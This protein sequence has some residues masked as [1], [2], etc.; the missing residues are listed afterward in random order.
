MILFYWPKSN[1]HMSELF[2]ARLEAYGIYEFISAKYTTPRCRCLTDGQNG[3]W[4]YGD[5]EGVMTTTGS[6]GNAAALVDK[7]SRRLGVEFGDNEGRRYDG[8]GN[9]DYDTAA[10][11]VQVSMNARDTKDD[12]REIINLD[13][14]KVVTVGLLE[15]ED[16]LP[17]NYRPFTDAELEAAIQSIDVD[18]AEVDW[19][20]GDD[21]DPYGLGFRSGASERCY[22]VRAPAND[23]WI[24][25]FDVPP[26]LRDALWARLENHFHAPVDQS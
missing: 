18:T 23:L 7:I 6:R 4:V 13:K 21:V 16:F 5:E 2:S 9:L 20:W 17:P 11:A 25:F 19:C 22:Y 12:P 24:D 10:A 8:S 14:S 26:D 1:L 15:E 3:L